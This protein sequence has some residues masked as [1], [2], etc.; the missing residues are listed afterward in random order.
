MKLL[1]FTL[2]VFVAFPF[3]FPPKFEILLLPLWCK[4]LYRS[5]TN[6]SE[7]CILFACKFK[8][9]R[10]DAACLWS[11]GGAIKCAGQAIHLIKTHL[12]GRRV[13]RRAA[14]RN[15][16]R[17]GSRFTFSRVKWQM[18]LCH[19]RLRSEEEQRPKARTL[20]I[21]RRRC[22]MHNVYSEFHILS[23]KSVSEPHE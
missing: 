21:W 1:W 5:E 23:L 6:S 20:F 17:R 13:W 2:F 8:G 7:Q 12:R 9:R 11:E 15:E 3:F 14:I 10:N 4:S 22:R 18:D 19:R 16:M